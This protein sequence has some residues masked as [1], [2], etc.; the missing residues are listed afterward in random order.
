LSLL[1][2][3]FQFS[4]DGFEPQGVLL[5]PPFVGFG[6]ETL[7]ELWA[8]WVGNDPPGESVTGPWHIESFVLE[9]EGGLAFVIAVRPLPWELGEV[10]CGTLPS[11]EG[12]LA[13]SVDIPVSMIGDS[14]VGDAATESRFSEGAVP[15]ALSGGVSGTLEADNDEAV[16]IVTTA[17]VVW[18]CET[19]MIEVVSGAERGFDWAIGDA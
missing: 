7:E 11:P 4:H 10:A 19:V 8:P 17:E 9:G 15:A 16:V 14:V 2:M 3:S 1:F 12:L 5:E 13:S 18:V 6:F